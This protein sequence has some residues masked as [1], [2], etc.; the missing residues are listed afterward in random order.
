M[1]FPPELSP[2]H[3]DD[4]DADIDADDE[5]DDDD[6]DDAGNV[7]LLQGVDAFCEDIVSHQYHQYWHLQQRL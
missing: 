4:D 6:H 3:N 2:G 5:D 1:V 7:D